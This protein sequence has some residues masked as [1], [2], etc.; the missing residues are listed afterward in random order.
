[1]EHG[2]GKGRDQNSTLS[3]CFPIQR[4]PAFPQDGRYGTGAAL[5]AALSLGGAKDP[6]D[7]G[8]LHQHFPSPAH[9]DSENSLPWGHVI[10]LLLGQT[11]FRLPW[12][13]LSSPC[14]EMGPRLCQF[15]LLNT[16]TSVFGKAGQEGSRN[17]GFGNVRT[18]FK[19]QSTC[20]QEMSF[21][22]L[23]SAWP[24]KQEDC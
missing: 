20:D 22:A 9:S 15:S 13:C 14:G 8:Q 19:L 18:F 17:V 7:S 3:L 2:F 24:G 1:M 6:T 23:S 12:R 4:S 21:V 10:S 5:P 11:G 16:G